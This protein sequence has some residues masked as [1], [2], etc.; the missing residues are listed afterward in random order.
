MKYQK[1]FDQL[2]KSGKLDNFMQ[3]KQEEIE[4]KKGFWDYGQQFWGLGLIINLEFGL[5]FKD[6]IRSVKMQIK[7]KCFLK[8]HVLIILQENRLNC[9]CDDFTEV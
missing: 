7:L 2:E 1:Q 6:T 5:R 3:K 9:N 4:K 8:G